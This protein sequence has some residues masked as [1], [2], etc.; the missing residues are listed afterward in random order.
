LAAK[1]VLL[2]DPNSQLDQEMQELLAN[3]NSQ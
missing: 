1:Q 3:V 2:I